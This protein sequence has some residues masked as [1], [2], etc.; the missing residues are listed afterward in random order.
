MSS[1]KHRKSV[2]LAR[3]HAVPVV[4]IGAGALVLASPAFQLQQAYAVVSTNVVASSVPA[5]VPLTA[6][7]VELLAS[8]RAASAKPK[9]IRHVRKVVTAP[10]PF[11]T[12]GYNLWYAANYARTAY[13]WGSGQFSC[14]QVMWNRESNWDQYAQNW[15]SG[16]YGIPQAQPGWKMASAGADWRTDPRTQIRWGLSYIASVYGS[17]CNAWSFWQWHSWY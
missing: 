8:R 9:A 16:A 1:G 12:V 10:Y 3:R 17:P 13:G 11:G 6:I 14:L 5:A 2:R 4:M 15:A 7:R